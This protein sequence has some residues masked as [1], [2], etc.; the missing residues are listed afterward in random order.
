MRRRT[1][2]KPRTGVH[3]RPRAADVHARLEDAHGRRP[4]HLDSVDWV[5]TDLLLRTRVG[6]TPPTGAKVIGRRRAAFGVVLVGVV[7]AF[8][9][10]GPATAVGE[11]LH[12][13]PSELVPSF[14][15][16]GSHGYQIS[17]VRRVERPEEPASKRLL[18]IEARHGGY[19]VSYRAR[20]IVT[21]RRIQVSFGRLGL[22]SVM[23]HPS[24][25]TIKTREPC[26]HD[27]NLARR[28]AFVGRIVFR[29]E[30][31][32]TSVTA[33]RALGAV[34]PVPVGAAADFPLPI[35]ITCGR[36]EPEAPPTYLDAR[37]PHG[38]VEFTAIAANPPRHSVLFLAAT[39]EKRGD[40]DIYRALYC[41][42]GAA[43]F[44]RD[45]DLRSATV[46]P[47]PPY[48][49]AAA[50]RRNADGSTSWTGTLAVPFPGR[51]TVALTGA[52]F[53][54]TL[55]HLGASVMPSPAGG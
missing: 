53:T 10:L 43:A 45:G 20:G 49:G 15:L 23:F 8:Q 55:A 41:V 47:P 44:V 3:R 7:A 16:R 1:D 31:G 38:S 40:I 22:V 24:S 28:G 46:S 36:S 51:G 52:G 34:G 18:L 6:Q 9:V 17:V 26:T 35:K 48:T 11:Q 50:F 13:K 30:R 42:A 32:Y 19:E 14:S 12:V 25:K 21:P 4:Q 39:A 54:A 27:I 5:L 29:G 2:G 33:T 37:T